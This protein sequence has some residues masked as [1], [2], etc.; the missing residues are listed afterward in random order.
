[1]KR[2][3]LLREA[4]SQAAQEEAEQLIRSLSPEDRRE[5]EQLYRKDRRRALSLIAR[6]TGK[7]RGRLALRLAAMALILAGGW[8]ALHRQAPPDRPP[9]TPGASV[10]VAPYYTDAFSPTVEPELTD[11]PTQSPTTDPIIPKT[12]TLSPTFS[13]PSTPT[14][15]PVP[16][17]TAAPTRA[18][19]ALIPPAVPDAWGGEYFLGVL[20]DGYQIA[21]CTEADGAFTVV[22]TDGG[23]RLT[24]TEH[25]AL[26]ALPVQDR[27]TV[28][29]VQWNNTVA[30]Q[31]LVGDTVTLTWDQDGKSFSL[32]SDDG[33][34]A[35]IARQVKKIQK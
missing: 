17:P 7:G 24:F 25:A 12:K 6:H 2:D 29:Y 32:S 9:V 34:T 31:S 5:A 21:Q 8:Y 10:S 14:T 28:T 22:Y 30:L 23:R 27:A 19:E 20:P 33:R 13:P 11:A 18:P 35:E 26:T 4:L 3:D 16:T 1:M 15:T